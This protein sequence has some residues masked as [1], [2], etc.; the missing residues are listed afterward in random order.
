MNKRKTMRGFT[1]I[2]L[3]VVVVI[4]GIIV[5]IAVP[6]YIALRN[7]ALEA[8]VKSNMHSVHM[9]VE[10]FSTLSGGIYPGDL[11]TRINQVAPNIIG[12]TG[13]MSLA[14]GVRVP[15]FPQDALLKPHPGFKNPFM[16]ANNVVDNLLV[17]FPPVPPGPPGGPQG[18]VYYSSYQLDGT[19]PSGAGQ[20]AYSY[21]VTG[22]GCHDPIPLTLP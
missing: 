22:F 2:E 1:L 16:P 21:R 4:I 7:R 12:N 9:S 20:P 8:S 10:E 15:P 18:C 6:N 5:S 17:G 14:A 13:N 19:T 3:M 11:D